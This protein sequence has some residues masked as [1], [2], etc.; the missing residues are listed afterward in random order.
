MLKERLAEKESLFG[1]GIFSV[2][3]LPAAIY[4]FMSGFI[5]EIKHRLRKD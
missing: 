5:E 3:W 1:L 2:M 4:M